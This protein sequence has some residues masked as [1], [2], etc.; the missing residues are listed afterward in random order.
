MAWGLFPLL[1]AAK[2]FSISQIGIVTATYPAVW[3]VGQLF[4]GKMADYFCKKQLLFSGMLLQAIAL[5]ALLFASSFIH[6]ILL[7]AILGWGTAMVY[8]TFLATI[9]ENTHPEDRANSFGVFRLWRDLGY[10]IGAV[11]T[12]VIADA[13]GIDAAVLVVG[14]LTGLSAMVI[15]YRMKCFPSVM[16]T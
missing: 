12:G 1:L 6:F 4:T 3:G 8:P 5:V 10:A 2:G 16:V 14:L 9:A 11:L 7:A 13:A 15:F